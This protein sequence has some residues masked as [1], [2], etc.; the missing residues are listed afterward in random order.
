MEIVSQLADGCYEMSLDH[1]ED[2]KHI[3]TEGFLTKNEIWSSFDINKEYIV[4]FFDKLL[5]GHL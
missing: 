3:M 5:R 1:L 4:Q 2:V